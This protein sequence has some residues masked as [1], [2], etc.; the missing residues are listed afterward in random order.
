MASRDIGKNVELG[1][2]LTQLSIDG[3]PIGV[4]SAFQ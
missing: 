4:E 3:V 1:E 2:E